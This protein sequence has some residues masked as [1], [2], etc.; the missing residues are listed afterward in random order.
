[1][2][3]SAAAA[4]AA[5]GL[6]GAAAVTAAVTLLCTVWWITEAIPLPATALVPVAVFPLSGVLSPGQV[7]DAY[8]NPL[9]LLFLGGFLLSK[10]ME[11]SG[12]HRRIALELVSRVG[13]SP[14]RLVLAFMLSS[15][16]LSMWVSNTATAIMLLP[17]ALAT[18]ERNSD[19]RLSVALL[20]GVAYGASIGGLG[21]PIGSPPNLVF[22]RVYEETTGLQMSFLDWMASCLPVVIVFLPLAALWLTRG[23]R[24]DG[25]ITLPAVEAWRSEERRVL[26]IFG[27]AAL[28]WVLRSDPAGG[29]SRWLGLPQ[30]SDADVA[31]L[32][33][34]ALFILPNGRGGRLLDWDSAMTIPWGM[35]ILFAGGIAIAK[36]F[37]SSGLS[38]SIGTALSG[39]TT[40]PLVLLILVISLSVTFLTE[41]NSNTATAVLLMPILAAAA[42]AAEMDPR[43]LMIPAALSASCAF[44]LPVAT[45][46]NAVVFGSGQ[47]PLRTMVHEGLAL[48][49]IGALIITAWC[50]FRFS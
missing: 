21:T 30:A 6:S 44:M 47:L 9:I 15:A 46:P 48:N 22:L 16:L 32:A 39:A 20:L 50:S 13:G 10:A 28:A 38:D 8:G 43:L 5:A 27:L 4:V 18:L 1:M 49:L 33:A 23:V 31:L 7:A 11:R 41:I 34:L 35:L 36:A 17:V 3:L 42:V 12:A 40:L 45:P 29:W 26:L 19:R 24:A 2:A 14:R 37:V 25:Q